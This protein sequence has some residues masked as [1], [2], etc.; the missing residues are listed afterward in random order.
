MDSRSAVRPPPDTPISRRQRELTFRN[1]LILE[2]AEEIFAARGFQGASIEDIATHAEVAI[3]TLY[4]MFGSKEDIFA[5]L[6]EHRQDEFLAHVGTFARA[7]S[8]PQ[9]Q[10]ERLVEAVFRYFDDHQAAFRIYI[11][12]THGFPWHIRSS[13]GERSFAKYQEILSL[14]A[15]LIDAAIQRSKRASRA[16]D[17]P[18]RLAAAAMGVLNGLLTR[19][20]T[21]EARGNLDEEITYANSLIARLLGISTAPGLRPRPGARRT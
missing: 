5:T 3:A 16:H 14:L 21:G 11:G 15:S 4:K 8:T 10:I 19:R 18:A 2:A 13:L 6:V 9:L 7:G 12:A 17:D 1:R 20:H